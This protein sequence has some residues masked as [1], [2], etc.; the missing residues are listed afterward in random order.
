[1]VY[2]NFKNLSRR[3]ASDKVLRDK[4][5][6][7]AKNRKYDGF[8]CGPTSVNYKF[9]DNQTSGASTSALRANKPTG[10]GVKSEIISKQE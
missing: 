8:H 10:N 7:I 1:M 5:F 3:R 4:A 6:N 2:G 9:F